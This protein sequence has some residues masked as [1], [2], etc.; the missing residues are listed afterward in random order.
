MSISHFTFCQDKFDKIF[1]DALTL[2]ENK[3]SLQAQVLFLRCVNIKNYSDSITYPEKRSS[4]ELYHI[5]YSQKK[6]SEA[7]AYLKY[8]ENKKKKYKDIC[9]FGAAPMDSLKFI[10]K[11]ALCYYHLDKKDTVISILLPK[12]FIDPDHLNYYFDSLEI[13]S[14]SKFLVSTM[15]EL[16]GKYE[17]KELFLNALRKISY[18]K[19]VAT[20]DGHTFI[21]LSYSLNFLN[22]KMSFFGYSDYSP[23]ADKKIS[24][25]VSV[26]K[27]WSDLTRIPI[28]RLI[29]E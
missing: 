7:L 24:D 2:L 19:K 4:E 1:T 3:D 27:I 26:D 5:F 12:V 28:Y 17:T 22:S 14:I 18:S 21:E 13:E 29:L 8:T 10:Y 23:E 20:Q 15:F 16:Y 9:H 11:K 25:G 6:Y